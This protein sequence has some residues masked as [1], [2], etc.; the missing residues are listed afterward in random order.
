MYKLKFTDIAHSNLKDL[1]E[2]R[3]FH[4]RLKSVRKALG[5][6]EKNPRH[7]SLH[8]HKYESLTREFGIEI[9]EAYAENKMD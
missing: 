5:Y 4:K 3:N 7:P 6:L 8:T 9:F 2:N 1:E